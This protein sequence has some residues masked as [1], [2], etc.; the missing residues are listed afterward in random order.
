[1]ESSAAPEQEPWL[2]GHSPGAFPTNRNP[3]AGASRFGKSM[4]GR[5][6]AVQS[7]LLFGTCSCCQRPGTSPPRPRLTHSPRQV[8]LP[9]GEQGG[10]GVIIYRTSHPKVDFMAKNKS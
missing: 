10:E 2:A 9:T 7:G 8:Y 3:G 4:T 1:M 5:G 6:Q